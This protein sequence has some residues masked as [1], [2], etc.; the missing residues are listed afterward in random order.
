MAERPEALAR[1]ADKLVLAACIVL[2]IWM[3]T[4][5]EQTR[6]ERG[7]AWAHRLTTPVEW[8]TQAFTDLTA[9]R[10][11]NEELRAEIEA[12]RMDLGYLE[13]VRERMQDLEARA[14]FYERDRGRLVPATVLELIVSRVPVQAKIRTFTDDS[15]QVWMPVVNEH[16]LVGRIRQVLAPDLAL[17]QL[18]TEEDSRISVEVARTGVTGLLRY[19]GRRFF[20][21]H[22]PQGEPVAIGDPVMSSGLGG[23]VPR[24]LNIGTVADVRSEPSELFQQVELETPVRFSAI[25]RVF[26]ITDDGPWYSR[27]NDLAPVA[28]DSAGGPDR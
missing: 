26:V 1:L 24:G 19:D 25:R 17:V 14:G 15:L 6:V 28:A 27:E 3:M 16:G 4:W 23:T 12:V 8:A 22:V 21:D 11:E 9:L 2:S 10:R 13:A 18:L 20:I 5:D 7:S